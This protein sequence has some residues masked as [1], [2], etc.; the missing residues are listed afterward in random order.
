MRV[1]GGGVFEL[2]QI[3]LDRNNRSISF[4]GVINMDRGP[5]EYVVVTAAGKVHESLVRTEAAP[6]HMHTAMLLIDAQGVG[7]SFPNPQGVLGQGKQTPGSRITEPSREKLAG[8]KVQIVISWHKDGQEVKQ[9]VEELVTNL[10]KKAT[11]QPG[12]WVY[13]GSQMVGHLFAAQ[14]SGSIVSLITDSEALVNNTGQGHDNDDIWAVN[15]NGVPSV[16]TPVWVTLTLP[17][18]PKQGN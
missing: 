4:P 15:T 2:G 11:M 1:V 16:N 18:A 6:Y 14:V 13:N 3:R 8:E 5:I 7:S 12:G 17:A 9:P 10:E